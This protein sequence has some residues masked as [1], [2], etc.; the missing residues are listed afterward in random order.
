[1]AQEARAIEGIELPPAGRYELDVA[2]TAVEFSARHMLTKTR[3]R[4]T[5]F[6]GT[7]EVGETPEDSSVQV[8]IQAASVQTNMEKRDEHLKSGDFLEIEKYP[9]LTFKS[10][11][12]RH[13][14]DTSF[15]LDGDL[16]IKGVTKPVTLTG[17]Y[18]GW[19]PDMQG[20]PMF[21]ASAKAAI[22]REDWDI[23]W[24]MVVETGGLLV[25]KK[26]ELEFDVEA[27]KVG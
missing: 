4:F 11:G 21:S 2:H 26:V 20:N 7:I 23:T 1:M 10:T 17:E 25:S 22:D 16:T 19:G 14:G 18:E 3:G 27:H 9:V 6:S 12:V 5:E 8:E 24:N 13:T 15:E